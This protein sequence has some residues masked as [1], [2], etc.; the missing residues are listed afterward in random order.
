MPSASDVYIT[1]ASKK[2]EWYDSSAV[3]GKI[4]YHGGYFR[5]YSPADPIGFEGYN[6]LHYFIASS[7]SNRIFLYNYADGTGYGTYAADYLQLRDSSANIEAALYAGNG[8]F[9]SGNFAIGTSSITA[10]S[11]LSVVGTLDVSANIDVG[12]RVR[13]KAGTTK[14]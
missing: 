8:S 7:K 13:Y 2:I 5:M 6:G 4:Y 3:K 1:P 11:M 12:N 10:G 14:W 9:V